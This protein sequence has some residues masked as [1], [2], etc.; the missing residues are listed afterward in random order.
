MEKFLYVFDLESCEKLISAGYRLLKSDKKNQIYVF[1]DRT[2]MMFELAN[3]S[4]VRSNT[5][6]F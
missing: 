6:T 3:V 2:D 5:L 1:A 4:F